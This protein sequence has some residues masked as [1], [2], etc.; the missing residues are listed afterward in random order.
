LEILTKW[1]NKLSKIGNQ[2]DSRLDFAVTG[3][4]GLS[5]YYFYFL[6]YPLLH[7]YDLGTEHNIHTIFLD[8][9][10]DHHHHVDMTISVVYVGQVLGMHHLT[11]P[12]ATLE[13][14]RFW[15]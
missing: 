12:R 9:L 15:I 6:D 4:T 3:I 10:A 11:T 1:G 5:F 8:V 13:T 2:V 7:Q 14:H